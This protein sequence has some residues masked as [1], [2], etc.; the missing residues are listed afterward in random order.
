MAHACNRCFFLLNA[1]RIYCIDMN[2]SPLLV[3]K[4]SFKTT[5][6]TLQTNNI[7]CYL[8]RDVWSLYIFTRHLLLSLISPCNN[9]AIGGAK[10]LASSPCYSARFSPCRPAPTCHS[11]KWRTRC[12]HT[13]LIYNRELWGLLGTR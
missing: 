6:Q 12:G 11:K 3:K 8:T 2:W 4:T 5:K 13:N 7:I 1:L 10:P 9:K